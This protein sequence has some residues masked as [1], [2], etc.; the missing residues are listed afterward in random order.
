M[1]VHLANG[2]EV[3]I[4]KQT[5]MIGIQGKKRTVRRTIGRGIGTGGSLQMAYPS[6]AYNATPGFAEHDLD[7]FDRVSAEL[8]WSRSL[9]VARRAFRRDV[10]LESVL[11]KN[12]E[13][14]QPTDFPDRERTKRESVGIRDANLML[15]ETYRQVLHAPC[16][17]D[18][19]F[20]FS[21]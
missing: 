15:P 7:E 2:E 11:E 21:A 13:S 8:A 9:A 1:V 16:T 10:D 20:I 5:Q 14:K 19:V 12:V 17:T 3:G 6:Y 4:V 18:H